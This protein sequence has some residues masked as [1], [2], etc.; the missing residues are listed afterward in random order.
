M[1]DRMLI[2]MREEELRRGAE[3]SRRVGEARRAAR[4][5]RAAVRAA[6]RPGF[7]PARRLALVIGRR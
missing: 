5:T 7:R 1:M 4:A 2:R 3:R 6:A